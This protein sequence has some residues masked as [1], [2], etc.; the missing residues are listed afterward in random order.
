MPSSLQG[1][2][3]IPYLGVMVDMAGCP[4]RCRHCWLGAHPNGSI[5][6]G[7][8]KHIAQEFKNWRDESGQGIGELGFFSWWR[9]PDYREDY[10]ELWQLEQALSSPGRA[11]RFDLLSTWRLAR[12]E[13][14]AKWAADLPL[15]TCQISFFG[16]EE[17][18]DWGMRRKGAFQDQLLATERCL[19]AG[20]IPRWQLFITKRCLGE[21][22][23]F[24]TLMDTL[25]LRRRCE[26]IGGQFLVFLG[27][28]SPEGNGYALENIRLE[29]SDLQRIPD[30]LLRIS[31]EG[32][33]LLGLPEYRLLEEL[34]ACGA[35]ANLSVPSPCLAVNAGYDVYPNIAEPA[36]WWRLGNLKTDGIDAVMQAFL[37][38]AS[39]GM[40]ANKTIPVSMLS[41]R[42]GRF[43]SQKLYSRSD[44]LSRLLHQW[45]EDSVRS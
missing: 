8:F 25:R 33:A 45:G 26:A 35:P 41:K 4:N 24:V 16:M 1:S 34:S 44:L 9:E 7:E 23:D 38:E 10:R 12:D 3:A 18:T 6:T 15:K 29:E 43:D 11:K 31:R 21:L 30:S 39:P 40:K 14:Y 22:H 42:Y 5:T 17:T 37:H 13:R 2:S 19:D 20:I 28:I 27:G 36:A 32:T